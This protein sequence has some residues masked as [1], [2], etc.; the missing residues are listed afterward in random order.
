L[1][2]VQPLGHLDRQREHCLAVHGLAADAVFQRLAIQ[3]LHCDKRLLVALAD[4]INRADVG[5]IQ[6]RSRPRFPTKSFQRLRV[7]SHI[8]GKELQSD[9]AS[10]MGV[11]GLVN[12]THPAPAEFFDD[13]VVRNRLPDHGLDA[14]T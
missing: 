1:R 12:H 3:K 2:G 14:R 7:I 4:L 10:K 13:A 6:G 5:M 9:E 11:L 8:I